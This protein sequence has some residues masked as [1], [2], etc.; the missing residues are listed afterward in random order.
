MDDPGKE[1][2]PIARELSGVVSRVGNDTE[3]LKPGDRVFA[4]TL[5]H[6][7]DKTVALKASLVTSIPNEL[8]YEDAATIPICFT[9]AFHALIEVGRLKHGQ[10]V[11]IY[12]AASVIGQAAIQICKA[13]GAQVS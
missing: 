9:T 5:G 13:V 1:I 11:L 8:S 4:V 6:C 12:G 2:K 10:R 7:L 3:T